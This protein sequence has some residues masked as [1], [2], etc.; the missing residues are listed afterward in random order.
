MRMFIENASYFTF[1]HCSK[2]DMQSNSDTKWV[3]FFTADGELVEKLPYYQTFQPSVEL[4][5]K[6]P[7]P[8]V[9]KVKKQKFYRGKLIESAAEEHYISFLD[10]HDN[11][12][13][14]EQCATITGF[15][16]GYRRL[17]LS[18]LMVDYGHKY[19]LASNSLVIEDCI[20]DQANADIA[21]ISDV[22]QP[23]CVI[24]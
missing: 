21:A 5:P 14:M 18:D 19:N 24:L 22:K 16:G 10:K 11:I 7:K 20:D 3:S 6:A 9:A 8:I 23:V 15:A 13:A 2:P 17:L 12:I 4:D 1:D